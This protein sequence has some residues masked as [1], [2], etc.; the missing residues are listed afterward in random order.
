[1][2]SFAVYS[3]DG[4][5]SGCVLDG[6]G[7]RGQ[8]LRVSLTLPHF[9]AVAIAAHTGDVAA[10]IP[11][12]FAEAVTAALDHVDIRPPIDLGIQKIG[13]HWHPRLDSHPEHAWLRTQIAEV[14]A[15]L[16]FDASCDRYR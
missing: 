9:H 7:T 3:Q 10:L 6:M 11:C 12:Q 5:E 8:D 15:E 1:A 4:G 16:E 13:M 14:I 2:L